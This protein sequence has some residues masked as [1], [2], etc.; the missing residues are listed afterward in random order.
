MKFTSERGI[1]YGDMLRISECL[2]CITEDLIV[3]GVHHDI[4]V[5]RRRHDA[6]PVCERLEGVVDHLDKGTVLPDVTVRVVPV[7]PSC[8]EERAA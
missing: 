7:L 5:S 6:V 3:V 4:G 1:T 8:G 2:L